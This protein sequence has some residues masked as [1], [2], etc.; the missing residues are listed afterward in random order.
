MLFFKHFDLQEF[1]QSL[2]D[3]KTYIWDVHHRIR[4]AEFLSSAL[5]APVLA[6]FPIDEECQRSAFRRIDMGGPGG[7]VW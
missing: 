6:K 2:R 1:S 7:G 3:M 4:D 5:L